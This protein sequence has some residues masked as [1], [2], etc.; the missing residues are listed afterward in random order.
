M[1]WADMLELENVQFSI[2]VLIPVA[3]VAL[4]FGALWVWKRWNG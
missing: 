4:V 1:T 3:A 2:R